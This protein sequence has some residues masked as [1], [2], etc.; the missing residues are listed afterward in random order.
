M[1][2]GVPGSSAGTPMDLKLKPCP[3]LAE[4]PCPLMTPTEYSCYEKNMRKQFA[5]A[6]GQV[7]FIQHQIQNLGY[8]NNLATQKLGSRFSAMANEVYGGLPCLKQFILTGKLVRRK[9]PPPT[10]DPRSLV[11]D[12]RRFRRR[13]V[14]KPEVKARRRQVYYAHLVADLRSGKTRDS[15]IY[16][17]IHQLMEKGYAAGKGKG[18]TKG[19][20]GS[21]ADGPA[22]TVSATPKPA[23]TTVSATPKPAATTASATP[24]PATTTASA[25][26][27]RTAIEWAQLHTRQAGLTAVPHPDWE[28]RSWCGEQYWYHKPT[29]WYQRIQQ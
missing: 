27:K 11:V 29:G 7:K 17:R 24:K 1:A 3:P 8:S 16:R 23:A 25:T 9:L 19:T 21:S 5:V 2:Q 14:G 20:S 22:T 28:L 26:P 15:Q 10:R 12:T 13:H 4:A 6:P 18:C